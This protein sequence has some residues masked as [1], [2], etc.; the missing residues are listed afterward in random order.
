MAAPPRRKAILLLVLWLG[1]VTAVPA[2]SAEKGRQQVSPDGPCVLVAYYS[3][4]GNTEEMARAVAAGAA[5]TQGVKVVVRRVTDVKKPDLLAA[6]GIILGC[7]THYANIPGRMKAIIDD[8]AWKLKIDFTDKVGGA[9]STGGGPA[10]GKEHVVI[11]LLLF[12]INN[13][14]V[15]AGPLYR[16]ASGSD[17]WGEIGSTATTGPTDPG[18]SSTELQ[19]ARQLGRRIAQL[20]VKLQ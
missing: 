10:G 20:A 7:P 15:V 14:M 16:D 13:R 3:E 11:S 12:M 5:E 17:E 4:T 9:F 1:V 2:A 19:G 8:W 6:D 18:I